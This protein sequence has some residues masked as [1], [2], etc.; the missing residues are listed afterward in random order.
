MIGLVG[1]CGYI[2]LHVALCLIEKVA[3]FVIL[4]DLSNCNVDV[5]NWLESRAGR[6]S[7]VSIGSCGDFELVCHWIKANEIKEIIYLGQSKSVPESSEKPFEYYTNNLVNAHTLARACVSE[8]VRK[9]VY[10][11]SAAVY[12]SQ[13][14]PITEHGRL[15]P[16]SCYGHTK[17]ACEW[18]LSDCFSQAE[19]DLICLRYFNPGGCFDDDLAFESW[20]SSSEG[21]V[22][23]NLASLLAGDVETFSI[24][25]VDHD[26]PDGTAV[27]DYVHVCDL[28]M[29]HYDLL[30]LGQGKLMPPAVVNIGNGKGTSILQ[31]LAEL[32]SLLQRS[33]PTTVLE[34]RFGDIPFSVA[35]TSYFRSLTDW[36]PTRSYRE[37]LG[38]LVFFCSPSDPSRL[39]R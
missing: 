37:I 3:D 31:V 9:F 36:A 14:Y 10:S 12:E 26:T 5:I 2:G 15:A 29:A 7:I 23:A 28:A 13:S 30:R 8:N 4:D 18:L 22:F 34:R 32:K 35:D 24:Y 33:I 25:G 19:I 20:I 1:G 38:Q 11:S 6:G 27:R 17:L 39:K 21:G 16:T